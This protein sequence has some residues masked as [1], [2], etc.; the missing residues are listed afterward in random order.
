MTVV[1]VAGVVYVVVVAG[2]TYVVEVGTGATQPLKPNRAN[3][4]SGA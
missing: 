1:L 2:V 3:E 4:S